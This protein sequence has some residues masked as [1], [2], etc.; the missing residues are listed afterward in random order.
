MTKK[1]LKT[2]NTYKKIEGGWE[3]AQAHNGTLIDYMVPAMG[4]LDLLGEPH[5]VLNEDE[6]KEKAAWRPPTIADYMEIDEESTNPKDLIGSKKPPI[7]LLPPAGIIHGAMAMKNGASKY[8]PYNFRDK[9]VQM[10]IYLDA[11]LRHTLA[12]IDGEDVAEDSQVSHL[13][14]IIAGASIILD[15]QENNNLIDN[16]PSKGNT[17][18][19]L[20]RLEKL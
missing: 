11:I 13:G 4:R 17:P 3:E 6:L 15:C 5:S 18:T 8:G 19:L 7:S 1:F 2:G 14:H 9:K 16:R 10:M 20:K 12:L